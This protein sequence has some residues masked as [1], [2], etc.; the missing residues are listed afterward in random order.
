MI[1]SPEKLAFVALV[2][3]SFEPSASAERDAL[4]EL[5]AAAKRVIAV[6]DPSASNDMG[7]LL[8]GIDYD[9]LARPLAHHERVEEGACYDETLRR[10]GAHTDDPRLGEQL[11]ALQISVGLA[12]AI[13]VIAAAASIQA[14]WKQR[15]DVTLRPLN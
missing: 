14:T 15:S 5:L 6:S 1:R 13:V 11:G 3:R 7:H 10:F 8:A 4:H 9:D 12:C 2:R